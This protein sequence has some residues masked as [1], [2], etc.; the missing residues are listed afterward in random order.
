MLLHIILSELVQE[1][2]KKDKSAKKLRNTAVQENKT[3]I[4]LQT[5]NLINKRKGI[6]KMK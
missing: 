3:H 4:Q 1:E 6:N 2:M 5:K